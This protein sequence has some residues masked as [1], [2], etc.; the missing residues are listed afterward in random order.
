[1]KG[2]GMK[3][4]EIGALLLVLLGPMA[5]IASPEAPSPISPG[6]GSR[7]VLVERRCPTFSWTDAAAAGHYQIA[8]H[9][10]S[11]EEPSE[12]FLW[13]IP[14][15]ASSW[16]PSIQVAY[17]KGYVEKIDSTIAIGVAA[18]ELR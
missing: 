8:V 5:A 12:V 10:I 17:E 2:A 11:D 1:M 18:C 13:E 9:E 15:G 4:V 3:N 14:V 16:T 7:I 6:N